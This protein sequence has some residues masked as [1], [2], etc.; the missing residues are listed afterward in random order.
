MSLSWKRPTD[1]E[2]P[3]IWFE[4]E[5][6]DVDGSTVVKYRVQDL[7]PNRYEEVLHFM[8]TQ[9]FTEEALWL[10]KG[11][12]SQSDANQRI[13]FYSIRFQMCY[14]MKYHSEN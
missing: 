10:A 12:V 2:F 4:F 9:H 13:Y 7:P 6:T 11:T 5:A 1:I 3:S 14:Q 8:T